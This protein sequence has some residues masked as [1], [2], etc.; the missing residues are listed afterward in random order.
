MAKIKVNDLE[1]GMTL[2]ADVCDQ[3]G[4]FILGEGCELTQKHLKALNA[5]GIISVEIS[6]D[7][8]PEKI[9]LAELS[10]EI[11]KT[12]EDQVNAR[13]KH[14]DMS[15]PFIKELVTESIR[16]ISEQLRE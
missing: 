6:G 14:N 4:R 15:H 12:L 11:Y 13:F 5:W 9:V 2:T 1:V 16:F 8:L 7:E 3:N 10:P